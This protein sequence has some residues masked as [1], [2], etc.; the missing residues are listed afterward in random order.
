MDHIDHQ[1]TLED[2]DNLQIGHF[3]FWNR[4]VYV[5][6]RTVDRVHIQYVCSFCFERYNMDGRPRQNAQRAIHWHGSNNNLNERIEERSPHCFPERIP[7][8]YRNHTSV[9]IGIVS[10]TLIDE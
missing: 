7:E 3:Y 1:P 6:A 8:E 2:I 5:K 4:Q 10:A 9:Y